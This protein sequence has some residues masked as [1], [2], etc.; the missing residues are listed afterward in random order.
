MGVSE[1]NIIHS[2]LKPGNVF[3]TNDGV[4]KIFDFGIARA[5]AKVEQRK[6]VDDD[7]TLFD[8]GNLGA[9]TPVYAS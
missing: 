2:D 3:I 5:V 9:L 4:A 7:K 1:K 6:N 8:A